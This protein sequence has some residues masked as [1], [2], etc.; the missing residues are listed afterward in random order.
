[1]RRLDVPIL[2][3]PPL[4]DKVKLTK[5]ETASPAHEFRVLPEPKG[6]ADGKW[7]ESLES[8]VEHALRTNGPEKTAG[9]FEDPDR[10]PEGPGDGKL[11]GSSARRT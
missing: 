3:N 11:R 7:L 1:M 2:M 10:A 4:S 5:K 6:M 9:L 8:V